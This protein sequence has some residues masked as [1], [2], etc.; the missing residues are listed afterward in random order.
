MVPYRHTSMRTHTT[1]YLNASIPPTAAVLAVADPTRDNASP[2][3]LRPSII[4]SLDWLK[5]DQTA[6]QH[7]SINNKSEGKP[8]VPAKILLWPMIGGFLPVPSPG[9]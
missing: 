4:N 2:E 6:Q 9:M 3:R 8:F 1:N 5:R 7:R